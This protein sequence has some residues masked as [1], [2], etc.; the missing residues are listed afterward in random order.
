MFAFVPIPAVSFDAD[1]L[2]E[3]AAGTQFR[4]R[5]AIGIG[6]PDI[7][8]R[9]HGHAVRLVLVTQH[10]FRHR[11]D[12]FVLRV[13]L[14]QLRMTGGI[15]LQDPKIVFGIHADRGNPA[16]IGP[17]VVR[18]GAEGIG[19]GVTQG[20]SPLHARQCTTVGGAAICGIADR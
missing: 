18:R 14:E 16:M 12:Q 19:E 17:I 4:D 10:A 5:A 15:A 8:E 20:L 13:I 7:V 2:D 3:L 11:Q 6:D 1:D 9:I